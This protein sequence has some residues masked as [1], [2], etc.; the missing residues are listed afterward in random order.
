MDTS[1]VYVFVCLFDYG[2]YDFMM[3]LMLVERD[4]TERPRLTLRLLI[5]LTE[6]ML[7]S[8]T[9]TENTRGE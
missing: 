2:R 5:L 7:R 3:H 8:F 9:E 1:S 4:M 6:R